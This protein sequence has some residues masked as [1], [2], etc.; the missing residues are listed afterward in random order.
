M[1]T[2]EQDG[3]RAI[4]LRLHKNMRKEALKSEIQ[5][6]L[7]DDDFHSVI[8]LTPEQCRKAYDHLS[9]IEEDIINKAYGVGFYET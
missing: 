3:L 8:R 5:K 9:K 6:A 7:G 4:V 1:I 2:I